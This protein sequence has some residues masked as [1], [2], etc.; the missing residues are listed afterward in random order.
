MPF[1]H[2]VDFE[3]RWRIAWQRNEDAAE[4]NRLLVIIVST[5]VQR[6]FTVCS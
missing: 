2:S 4:K 3:K 1:L 5:I 6:L